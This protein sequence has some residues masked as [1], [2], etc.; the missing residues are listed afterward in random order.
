M[1][2]VPAQ[3]AVVMGR[4]YVEIRDVF[5]SATV[6]DMD[7]PTYRCLQ[8]AQRG[9]RT[10]QLAVFLHEEWP[11]AY[12]DVVAECRR[13][14]EARG[15]Y[16]ALLAYRY[17]HVP[18]REQRSITH[19]EFDHA[20]ERWESLARPPMWIFM[21]KVGSEA[22][23]RLEEI[24]DA[25]LREDFPESEVDRRESKRKQAAFRDS[26]ASRNR[27]VETFADIIELGQRV[28]VAIPLYNADIARGAPER[29]SGARAQVPDDE[30]GGIGRERQIAAMKRLRRDFG[31]SQHAASCFVVHGDELSG[32]QE[33]LE[34][35]AAA[36]WWG[37][38]VTPIVGRPIENGSEAFRGW[39]A[40]SLN[41]PAAGESWAS[42]V[43][44]LRSRGRPNP[45][46][47]LAR[48]SC[49]ASLQE[50][51]TTIWQPLCSAVSARAAADPAG[52]VLLVVATEESLGR[53]LPP[54][55]QDVESVPDDAS[56]LGALPRCD[57]ITE[58]QVE[59]W[60]QD[61]GLPDQRISEVARRATRRGND[62]DGNPVHVFRRLRN[63][64]ADWDV[65]VQ[66]G[67]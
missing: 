10:A 65:I 56:R 5:L 60:L 12:A 45:A 57:D 54:F 26:V 44:L 42:L 55:I 22:A 21:P 32:Q 38:G 51:Y 50:F 36:K 66:G 14:I 11:A 49:C 1:L 62:V 19:I 58:E 35:L 52:R 23:L 47:I 31:R 30:L 59:T 25:A 43:E 2:T 67:A 40:R 4:Q 24:A 7:H 46:V 20:F 9:L 3:G 53:P 6:K 16:V 17:G 33:F 27:I 37:A 41:S 61:L 15:G 28:S 64:L 34:H 8:V 18:P 48:W 63:E 13:R 39:I 29:N